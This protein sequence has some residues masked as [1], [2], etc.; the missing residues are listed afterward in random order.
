MTMLVMTMVTL[1]MMI[2]MVW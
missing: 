1:L 2:L